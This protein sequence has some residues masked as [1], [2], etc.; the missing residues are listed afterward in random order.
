MSLKQSLVLSAINEKLVELVELEEV[1]PESSPSSAP[2]AADSW[3]ERRQILSA[4][5]TAAVWASQDKVCFCEEWNPL[6]QH[7]VF[8]T[9]HR[10]RADDWFTAESHF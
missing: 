4:A 10:G 9:G 7:L 2:S 1:L 5:L 8:T 3:G 6:W